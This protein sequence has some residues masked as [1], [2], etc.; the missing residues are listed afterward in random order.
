VTIDDLRALAATRLPAKIFDYVD[1]GAGDGSTD[2]ANRVDL[3]QI[4]LLPLCLRDVIDID[5]A[6]DLLGDSFRLPIGLSPTAFHHLVH[7]DGEVATARAAKRLH[8]PMIVSCM[9]SVPLERIAVASGNQALWL[10][11]YLFRDSE[12]TRELVW[13]AE[14]AGFRAIVVN[15]GCPVIGK[16]DRMIRHGFKLPHE[17]IAADSGNPNAFLLNNSTRLLLA[18]ELN[19]S[20][21]WAD[22]ERLCG[23][24]DL[25]VIVKGI[26][27]PRDVAPALDSGVA[28]LMVSNHGGRQLE[29]TESTIRILPEI[30]A[31]VS[32]RVPLL[33]DSGFRRGTDVIKGLALGADAIFLGRPIMWALAVNGEQGVVE[34]LTLLGEELTLAMQLVGTR[35]LTDLRNHATAIIRS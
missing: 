24:T 34:A 15:A 29:S 3:A 11:T 14:A 16:R 9:S 32:G 26:L 30:S 2:S 8:L 25:P 31:A 20:G 1:C 13:R 21:T 33:I 17:L 28:G 35:S 23:A 6:V 12:L 7:E 27:N 10:Q 19:A 22:V 5:L 18:A 4:R